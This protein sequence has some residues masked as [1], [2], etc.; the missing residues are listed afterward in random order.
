MLNLLY[1]NMQ[2]IA[3]ALSSI[4]YQRVILLFY[5]KVRSVRHVWSGAFMMRFYKFT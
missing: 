3:F 2:S 4:G 5:L 1:D